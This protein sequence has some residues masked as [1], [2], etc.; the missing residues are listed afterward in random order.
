[1]ADSARERRVFSVGT[2]SVTWGDIAAYA[3]LIGVWDE[4][5]EQAALRA[6]ASP[7]AGVDAD[8]VDRAATAFRHERGLLAADDLQAWLERRGLTVDGWLAYVQRSLAGTSSAAPVAVST[9]EIWAE[10]MCSGR[11]DELAEELADR[12]AIAPDTPLDQLNAAY[13]TFAEGVA[14]PDIVDR[15]IAS[16]R[17]DW[18]RVHY[19]SAIFDDPAAAA[20]AALAVR[21]DGVRLAEVSAL[22]GIDVDDVD[23]W[24]EDEEPALASL[25]VGAREGE[26]I[27]PVAVTDG[28]LIAEIVEKLPVDPADPA[29]R[30]RA[31]DAVVERAVRREADAR[32]VWHEPL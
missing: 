3:E 6:C 25:L 4:I 5:A 7:N 19:L 23:A 9:E 11:L 26:L 30:S 27:G 21:A 16:A 20:E 12:L 22:A 14:S 28:L 10:A 31:T 1:M 8:A 17:V 32:V 15:E 18:I 13:E 24:L 29:V 2:R